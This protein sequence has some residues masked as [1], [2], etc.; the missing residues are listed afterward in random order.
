MAFNPENYLKSS[1]RTSIDRVAYD[2]SVNSI[3]GSS[4]N[5]RGIAQD[6]SLRILAEG[7]SL[8]SSASL[9]NGQIEA[10]VVSSTEEMYYALAGLDV[11]RTN[12]AKLSNLRRSS[13][14]TADAI[15]KSNPSV[16]I[17]DARRNDRHIIMSVL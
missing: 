10:A 6:L 2:V 12:G 5:A 3:S 1:S 15:T 7:A 13:L 11:S 17:A 9:V 4:Q 14:N 8:E 16:K